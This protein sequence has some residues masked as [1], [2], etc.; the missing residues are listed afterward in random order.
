MLLLRKMELKPDMLETDYIFLD[1]IRTPI[2]TRHVQLPR[3]SW[4]VVRDYKGFCNAINQYYNKYNGVPHFIAFDHDLDAEHYTEGVPL[5]G[6]YAEKTGYDCAKWLAE[7][8]RAKGLALP[9]FICHSMNPVG[10]KNIEGFLNAA[11]L[12]EHEWIK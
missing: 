8:C 4:K 9:D 2:S 7:F 10:K 1:D 3:A 11:K 5:Y 12:F 6:T